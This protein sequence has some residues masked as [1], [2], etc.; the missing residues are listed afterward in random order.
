[1]SSHRKRADALTQDS[2]YM[3]LPLERK[4]EIDNRL[5][6]KL[7]ATLVIRYSPDDP[8]KKISIATASKH[9]P[10][11]IRQWGQA[12][13][14]NSGDRFKCCALLKGQRHT[15]DCTYVKVSV[16]LHFCSPDPPY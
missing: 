12:Q 8:R 6:K 14:R 11:S 4:L 16:F 9:V 3:L 13:I 7:A 2:N 5:L 10:T 1:M 15:R